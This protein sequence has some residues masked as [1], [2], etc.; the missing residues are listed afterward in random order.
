ML[1]DPQPKQ[2]FVLF[3]GKKLC[4]L[5]VFTQLFRARNKDSSIFLSVLE[6]VSIFVPC[7]NLLKFHSNSRLP[8]L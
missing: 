4:S 2:C 5:L 1:G 6:K 3:V 8:P 7:L